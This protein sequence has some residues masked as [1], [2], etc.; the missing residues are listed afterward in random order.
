MYPV[1]YDMNSLVLSVQQEY[2]QTSDLAKVCFC[3]R[4]KK[5]KKHAKQM[6]GCAS[7]NMA[8]K[9]NFRL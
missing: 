5:E 4:N 2:A 3:W 7:G 8:S 1:L 9:N 6:R